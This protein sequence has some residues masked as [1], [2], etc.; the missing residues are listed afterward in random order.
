MI[1]LFSVE[2]LF[3]LSSFSWRPDHR[4]QARYQGIHQLFPAV[5]KFVCHGN[6]LLALIDKFN[7]PSLSL[8]ID[9]G[10]RRNEFA[11]WHVAWLAE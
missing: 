2:L 1:R 7:I 10:K 8:E 3:L 9:E 4:R 6:E 5:V 11:E